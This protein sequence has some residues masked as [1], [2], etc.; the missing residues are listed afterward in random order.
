VEGCEGRYCSLTL[1]FGPSSVTK[2]RIREMVDLGYF[3][4]GDDKIHEIEDYFIAGLFLPAH[5]S[6]AEI[7]LKFKI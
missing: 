4:K 5:R 7:L 3:P 1:K 6:L 2:G